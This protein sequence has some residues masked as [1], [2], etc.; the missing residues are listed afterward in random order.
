MGLTS[1][2]KVVV[3]LNAMGILVFLNKLVILFIFGLCYVNV[4]QILWSFF[5]VCL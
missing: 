1:W 3:V 5:L 4:V 2:C